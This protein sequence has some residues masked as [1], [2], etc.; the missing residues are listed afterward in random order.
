[1]LQLLLAVMQTNAEEYVEGHWCFTILFS[2]LA[3]S[4]AASQ[5]TAISLSIQGLCRVLAM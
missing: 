4:K 2:S 5:A 1:M 3:I